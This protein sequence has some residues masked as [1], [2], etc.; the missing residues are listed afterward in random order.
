MNVRYRVTLN[1]KE[2]QQL[3][4]LLIGGRS[5][6]REVKHAQI[7]LA[8][9]QGATEEEIAKAVRSS[10]ATIY[11]TK[12]SFV[13]AGLDAALHEAQRPGAQRKLSDK[14]EALL[15]ATGSPQLILKFRNDKFSIGFQDARHLRLITVAISI[16]GSDGR[17][18]S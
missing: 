2:R 13:E 9:A 5:Q 18:L 6:V 15:I 17:P 8:A 12:R 14:E 3:Q 4:Q 1:D 10:A 11:R 16:F 7:L